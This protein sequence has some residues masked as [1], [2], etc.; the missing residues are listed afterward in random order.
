ML[1]I[2]SDSFG[3]DG[4]AGDS[5]RPSFDTANRTPGIGL[6]SCKALVSI[7]TDSSIEILGARMICGTIE[8]SFMV[9]I[10]LLPKNGT[11]IKEIKSVTTA[12]M[13]VFF[14]D[15]KAACNKLR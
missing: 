15:D 1:T 2:G 6:I 11:S 10:K 8:P 7:C 3:P 13:T 12:A 5:P 4:S 9:G 14:C